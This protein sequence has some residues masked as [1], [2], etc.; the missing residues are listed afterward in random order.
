MSSNKNKK[1]IAKI[2]AN[3][4][5]ASLTWREVSAALLSVGATIE[6]RKGSAVLIKIG[7]HRLALHKPHPQP[8]MKKYSIRSIR[9][10]LE[11]CEIRP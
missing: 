9:M 3:P 11:K 2:F 8:E 7:E 5:S 6:E 4:A 1:L 10:F